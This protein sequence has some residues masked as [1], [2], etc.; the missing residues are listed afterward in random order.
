MLSPFIPSRFR[1]S[2][3][4]MAISLSF[5][6]FAAEPSAVKPI[7]M[8]PAPVPR[9]LVPGFQIEELPIELTSVNNLEY[10]SDGRLFAAGYDGRF[11]LL[12]DSDEDGLEDQ[13]ITFWDKLSPNYPLGMVIKDGQPYA[14]MGDEIVG[15]HDLDGDGIP[16]HRQTAIRI[17]DDPALAE[18]AYLNHRR[19]DSSLGLA[20]GP[21]GAWYVTIGN[22]GFS[23]P[24]WHDQQHQPQ[25]SPEKFRGCLVRI[26]PDGRREQLA[27]GLRYVMSLQYNRHGDLFATDQEGATW[28]PNGNPFDELL[29]LQ[30][31]RHYGFP[32]RHPQFL[33]D[34]ID[35]PSVWDY[36]PQHQSTCG[37]RFNQE[38]PG[39]A[40]F[41]PSF[42]RDNALVTGESRGNLWRTC[43]AKTRNGYVARTELIARLGMLVVDCA[44]SPT[45][46]LVVCCH[47]G[48]PDWGNGPQGR[49]RIFKIRYRDS[50]QP[51]PVIAWAA[52]ESKTIVAFDR[53]L[54]ITS[55]ALES[56]QARITYGSYLDAGFEHELLRPGYAVVQMQQRQ[57]RQ[58]LPITSLDLDGDSHRLILE[59]YARRSASQ[60]ALTLERVLPEPL[61]IAF[62]LNGLT[63]HFR[64]ESGFS[65][66]GWLPHPDLAVAKQ[67][68]EPSA[69]HASL[70]RQL[71]QPGVLHLRGQVAWNNL[72]QPVA[73]PGSNLDYLPP[74][75]IATLVVHCDRPLQFRVDNRSAIQLQPGEWHWAIQ[76][77]EAQA[78]LP[79]TLEVPTPV[80]RLEMNFF[81][82]RD[83][84]PRPLSTSRFYLPFAEPELPVSLGR[85]IPELVGGDWMTGRALFRGKA[86]CIHCHTFRGEGH[87]VGPD[88][89]NQIHR[90]YTSVLRDIVEPNAIIHP[91]AIG[92]LAR[93]EDDTV[94]KGLRHRE[95]QGTLQLIQPQGLV[96]KF[97]KT[98]IA[99][100]KPMGISLMPSD[101]D[102]LLTAEELRDLLTY[103]L[104]DQPS[105]R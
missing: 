69:V 2:F 41:G 95:D 22:A 58:S 73:Q 11:H 9:M 49:G 98:D 53:P 90:D 57:P 97:R 64:A 43:L 20:Y 70:W 66:E 102:Q 50:G 48:K 75:E 40:I 37:F 31:S 74:A 44:I 25:Y 89:N 42:W 12:R 33:P 81:T 26:W 93:L 29:Y 65:W 27:S 82:D 56:T 34:V 21:D 3:L 92:Y 78:W 100:I 52:S 23:N 46:E 51:Q 87:T 45:G 101:Y 68:T 105:D 47:S 13:V 59:S 1:W 38:L 15:F 99:E 4:W 17:D 77:R 32:P 61:A 88:L 84:R 35:E 24:Y 54:P 96:V 86:A 60:Y 103:L 71:S 67:F 72:L 39:Q 10:A 28:C 62:Q 80:A 5:S 94:H 83:R 6:A 91:D 30:P 8:E 79:F 104:I 7:V 18:A 36:A 19:V 16:E 85:E 63:A 55:A 14:N 76:D